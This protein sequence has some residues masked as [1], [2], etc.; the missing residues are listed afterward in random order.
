MRKYCLPLGTTSITRKTCVWRYSGVTVVKCCDRCASG[1]CVLALLQLEYEYPTVPV[2]GG[3]SSN[4]LC[5]EKPARYQPLPCSTLNDQQ[6][7]CPKSLQPPTAIRPGIH[8]LQ[9]DSI[10]S[11]GGAETVY[12]CSGYPTL[13]RTSSYDQ[14]SEKR[15]KR[16]KKALPLKNTFQE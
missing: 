8:L 7:G 5:C 11:F 1:F 6:D 13:M 2:L 10:T 12:W 15:G 3:A 14:P 4:G 9:Y 16:P